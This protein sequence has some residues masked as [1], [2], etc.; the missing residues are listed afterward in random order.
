MIFNY[1]LHK[2]NIEMVK[3]AETMFSISLRTREKQIKTPRKY[4]QTNQNDCLRCLTI[5]SFV[6]DLK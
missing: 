1:Q 5:S 2:Q 4:T 6:M 3:K